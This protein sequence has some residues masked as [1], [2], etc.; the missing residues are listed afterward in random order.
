MNPFLCICAKAHHDEEYLVEQK[1]LQKEE[2]G[3]MNGEKEARGRGPGKKEVRKWRG[4]EGEFKEN[5]PN[6][7]LQVTSLVFFSH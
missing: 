7:L 3:R 1:Y 6:V 4:K 2:R 5:G